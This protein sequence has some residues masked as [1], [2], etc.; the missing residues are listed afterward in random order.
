MSIKSI[1]CYLFVLSFFLN[2]T[3]S[4]AQRNVTLEELY[5]MMDDVKANYYDVQNTANTY[6]TTHS[7]GKGSG[8]KQFKRWEAEM[9]YWIDEKGNRIDPYHIYNEYT[10]FKNESA[11]QRAANAGSAATWKELGPWSWDA[12]SGWNPGVG[13]IDAVEIDPKNIDHIL[14][15]SPEGGVW[16]TTNGGTSWVSLTDGIP[17]LKIGDVSIDPNNSNTYYVGTLGAGIL[18]STDGGVTLTQINS[19]LSSTATV[20]K[21]IVDPTNSNNVLIATTG[22]VY[23]SVN[24][25]T[26]WTQSST[27][28]SYDIEFKPGDPTTVYSCGTAFYRSTN[29]GASFSSVSL[30][31]SYTGAMRIAVTAANP[32]LVY[33]VQCNGSVFGA[34]YKST[35]SGAT[36]TSTVTGNSSNGTNYFGYSP[37]GT[38]NS[39]QGSYNIDIAASPSN[40]N[41]VHIAGIITWKTTNGGTSFTSTTEWSFPNTRGYTHCD[42]HALEF[43]GNTLFTGSDGGI[44]KSTDGAGTFTDLSK[45]LGIRMFYRLGLSATDPNM[46]AAGA[47]DN[48]VGIRKSDESWIDWLGAD[49]MEAAIDKSNPSIIYG[50][51]Q[52]GDLY[53]STNGG[54]SYTDI[55]DPGSGDWITPY[56]LDPNAAN[57][58]YAGYAQVHKSTNGGSSWSQ[59]GTLS[60]SGNVKHLTIA[61]SNS[62]YLYAAKGT[63]LYKTTNGGSSW[64]TI[65]SGLGGITI[66]RIAVH[67]SNPDKVAVVSSNSKVYTSDD[68]GATWTNITGNIP[69]SAGTRCLLYENGSNEGIY[70]GTNTGVYY[71]DKTMTNWVDYSSGLP[72]VPV[73]ELEIQYSVSKLRAATY[74]RGIWEIDTYGTS[75]PVDELTQEDFSIS[76]FPNPSTGPVYL[77]IYGNKNAECTLSIENMLGQIIYTEKATAEK[78]MSKPLQLQGANKG[79]YIVHVSSKQSEVTTKLLVE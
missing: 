5:N 11:A 73:N 63:T 26:S 18:K 17:Y 52:N 14:I 34:F 48:G 10:R 60:A 42:M 53:K 64:T 47:Q 22:G 6:F 44:Y 71:K 1:P 4:Q 57:T 65:S 43:S 66:N 49:G 72:T 62:S 30:G 16:K 29:S 35:N 15:G 8:Y 46:I 3:P 69:T 31:T 75:V 70:V 55:T 36:M 45:G 20:R 59:I 25:G 78:L 41:E 51:C 27:N 28:T 13:R 61:P 12:T 24:G 38:D 40:E 67:S 37:N 7:K 19:G 76:V 74:G 54:T 56:V 9:Q 58:I 2:S 50:A 33:A 77:H 39:G 79:V 23:R 21:I 68:G 32:N